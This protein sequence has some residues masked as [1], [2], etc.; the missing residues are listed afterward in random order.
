MG[1]VGWGITTRKIIHST[2]GEAMKSESCLAR[3]QMYIK[4]KTVHIYGDC[5]ENIQWKLSDILD[6]LYYSK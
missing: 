3:F 6:R 2:H 5:E 1:D 4:I